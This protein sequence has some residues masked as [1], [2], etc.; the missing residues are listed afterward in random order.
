[1]RYIAIQEQEYDRFWALANGYYREGEDADT[2]QEEMD[3]FIR[4]LFDKVTAGELAGCFAVE[5]E[6]TV[7]FALWALDT[8]AFAFSEMPGLG[9]IAEIGLLPDFRGQGQGRLLAAFA[10]SQLRERGMAQCYVSA[11]GPAQK[12]WRSCGYQESG[13]TGGSGLPIFIK[14]L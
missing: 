11:Y 3:A 4:F 6:K 10:E 2:P 13:K 14:D 9:T 12:F 1:M 7:G 5:N 8:E